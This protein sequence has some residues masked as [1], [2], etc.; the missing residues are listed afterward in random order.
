MWTVRYWA[1]LGFEALLGI[2]V[3]SGALSLLV[4]NDWRG[5]AISLA[6]I[7]LGGTL[8]WKLIRA[9]ARIQMPRYER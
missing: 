6:V 4:A 9:M 8:F 2:V 1:V 3:V 5:A 7:G